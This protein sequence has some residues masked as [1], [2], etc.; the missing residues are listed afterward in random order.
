MSVL[1]LIVT[2]IFL[3][4]QGRSAEDGC[5]DSLTVSD[6]P[7][8]DILSRYV[9]YKELFSNVKWQTFPHFYFSYANI[10]IS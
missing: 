8:A 10:K 2:C 9:Y 4:H 7:L 1:S 3:A 6:I 5:W